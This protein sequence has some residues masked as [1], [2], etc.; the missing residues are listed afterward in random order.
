MCAYTCKYM[1]LRRYAV[2]RAYLYVFVSTNVH[3]CMHACTPCVAWFGLYCLR[4]S[5]LQAGEFDALKWSVHTSTTYPCRQSPTTPRHV[6]GGYPTAEHQH[7]RIS[8]SSVH[9]I[10]YGLLHSSASK[11]HDARYESCCKGHGVTARQIDR[12][13]RLNWG[14]SC[15]ASCHIGRYLRL[16]WRHSVAFRPVY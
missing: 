6:L 16:N 7:Q 8:C 3:A 11:C 9:C 12:H 5:K 15:H 1:R 10:H 4:A 14:H 2:V 13:L